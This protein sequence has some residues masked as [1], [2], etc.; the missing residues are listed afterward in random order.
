VTSGRV[1]RSS[2]S[3]R[4]LAAATLAPLLLLIGAAALVPFLIM[5]ALS[6]TNFSFNLPGHDGSYVGG[7]NYAQALS[8]A[9][10]GASL[11]LQLQFLAATIPLELLLGLTVALVLWSSL[12]PTGWLLILLC[13]PLVLAPVT[14][15]MI[16]RLLLHGDYGPIGYFLS[17]ALSAQRPSILGS[18]GS[19]FWALVGVD[20]WQWTP[21]FTIALLAALHNIPAT[22]LAAAR[23]DGASP[24]RIFFTITLPL[25]RPA[26]SIALFLRLMDSFKEFDKIFVM[27]RGGPASATE[28]SSVFAWIVT[29]GHGDLA[30]G[31]AVTLLLYLLIYLVC[32]AAFTV[33]RPDWK[34]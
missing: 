3:D 11:I 10:F 20:I 14:V 23:I 26:L 24:V 5:L 4:R 32:A 13:V 8:D 7:S 28:L 34:H 21:F 6:I 27:T 30:Y 1:A 2:R 33:L 12:R 22:P 29:F 16:W 15:G 17:G 9:R 19:A 18:P 25:L 31:S